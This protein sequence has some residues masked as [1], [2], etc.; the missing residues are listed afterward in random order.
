MKTLYFLTSL[1][2]ASTTMPQ[3]SGAGDCS[4]VYSKHMH[5][6]NGTLFYNS[7]GDLRSV[8]NG[9]A[10]EGIEGKS[11]YLLRKRIDS[12]SAGGVLVVKVGRDKRAS[13][14]KVTLRSTFKD[15]FITQCTENAMLRKR[16]ESI[17]G[18]EVSYKQ[19]QDYVIRPSAANL[20]PDTRR[21]LDK[22][23]FAY[24]G[25]IDRKNK[26]DKRTDSKHNLRQHSLV[27]FDTGATSLVYNAV[28]SFGKVILAVPGYADIAYDWTVRVIPYDL[29]QKRGGGTKCIKITAPEIKGARMVR[30]NDLEERRPEFGLDDSNNDSNHFGDRS[31]SFR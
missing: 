9:E 25:S 30:I 29:D 2:L 8:E 1:V 15:K 27:R 23:Y 16:L 14:A 26:C 3:M 21:Q 28:R 6:A 22:L 5:K 4:T 13:E 7:G 31:F 17:Y 18:A 24:K 12:R 20:D 19:F 10:I 11:I